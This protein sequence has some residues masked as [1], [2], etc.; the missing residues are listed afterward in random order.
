MNQ[1][2]RQFYLYVDGEAI[3]VTKE[4]YET[5]W[6]YEDK[7]DYFMRLLKTSRYIQHKETQEEVVVPAREVPMEQ[8][9][10][11]CKNG[12]IPTVDTEERILFDIWMKQLLETLTEEEREIIREFYING[13]T[14]REMS[15]VMEVPKTNFRRRE[16][17]LRKK[18]RIL[19][20]DFL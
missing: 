20:N 7:E 3:A 5:F 10:I 15:A 8:Y 11:C 14:E 1:E 6:H 19:L 13:K 17:K 2:N 4:V 9:A 16:E 18:L 12:I